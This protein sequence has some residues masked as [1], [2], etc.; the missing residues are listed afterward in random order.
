MGVEGL[1]KLLEPSAK[2]VKLESLHGKKVAIDASI[3]LYHF[4][5]AMVINSYNRETLRATPYT[6]H[7]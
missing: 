5:A 4:T 6:E 3:W 1:W 7:I 2:M